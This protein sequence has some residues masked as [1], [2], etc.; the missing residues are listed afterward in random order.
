M[1]GRLSSSWQSADRRHHTE[2]LTTLKLPKISLLFCSF[3]SLGVCKTRKPSPKATALMTLNVRRQCCVEPHFP[4]AVKS[5][6][7]S[8]GSC[9]MAHAVMNTSRKAYR[10]Q[11]CWVKDTAK[12]I[13]MSTH[14]SEMTPAK[15]SVV[16]TGASSSIDS[17]GS[18]KT[19]WSC[20]HTS[21]RHVAVA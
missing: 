13:A 4:Y 2:V 17:I 11:R 10:Y 1:D 3:F 9:S 6:W 5:H 20:A 8:P 19:V 16:L 15:T 21:S 18:G 12:F 14:L 7:T